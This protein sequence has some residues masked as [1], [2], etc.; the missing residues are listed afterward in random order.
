[1]LTPQHA[2]GVNQQMEGLCLSPLPSKVMPLCLGSLAF[3]A[4]RS[5]VSLIVGLCGGRCCGVS[6]WRPQV[7]RWLHEQPGWRQVLGSGLAGVDAAQQDRPCL[8]ASSSHWGPLGAG[9]VH[10]ESELW[11]GQ[12]LSRTFLSEL[13]HPSLPAAPLPACGSPELRTPPATCPW[14][15]QGEPAPAPSQ[16]MGRKENGALEQALPCRAQGPT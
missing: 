1:M 10:C 4:R 6:V 7:P 2:L 15:W 11:L 16:A 8:S 14:A 12:E 5:L 9:G 13:W 3:R